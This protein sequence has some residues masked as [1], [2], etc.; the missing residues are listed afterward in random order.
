M[1]GSGVVR[2]RA[3]SHLRI[4]RELARFLRDIVVKVELE[5]K[6]ERNLQFGEELPLTEGL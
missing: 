6:G 1:P 3:L 5:E 2:K 4:S